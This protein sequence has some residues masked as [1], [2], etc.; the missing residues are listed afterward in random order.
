MVHGEQQHVVVVAQ[1][2]Q[3]AADQRPARQVERRAASS[4]ASRRS[5]ASASGAAAQVVLR[6]AGSALVRRR[7]PLHRLR[8]PPRAKVVRSAS[9]RATIRSSARTQRGPVQLAPQP[10]AHG[11]VVRRARA[12]QLLEEPQPLLRE[13]QRQVRLALHRLDRRQ[14]GARDAV[15]SPRAKSASTGRV[16]QVAQRAPPPP[17]ACRTREITCTASSECPPSSKKLS[18]RPTRSTPQHLGPDLGQRLLD[19]ALRRLVAARARSASPSGAG[20]ALRSSL[21]FGV[22]GSASSRTKAAGT[23]Y[24]GS[25]SAR[26]A[27]SA[28]HVQP[29]SSADAVRHQPLVARRVLARQHHRLAHAADARSS[30]ASISPS[31]M[32]K[33]RIFTWK[34]LRPRNS[35]VPSG[36]PAPQVARPVQPR[37]GSR[38]NGSGTN[39]SAVSS[40]RSR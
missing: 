37:P 29:R 39:R 11:D 3:P 32:R 9:C 5:S 17:A 22:S 12:L 13:R 15:S 25:R 19:L 20:S 26:C 8:R 16:E 35:I 6:A 7:D 10:Q 40:G 18:W 28:S 38:A 4:A 24:S 34:S 23:M 14:L 31:S 27:R 2:H 33:P 21:P 36:T 30:R 1:P